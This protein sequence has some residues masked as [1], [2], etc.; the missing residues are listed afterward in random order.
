MSTDEQS[1][2]SGTAAPV[3][4]NDKVI[5][6][7]SSAVTSA[8]SDCLTFVTTIPTLGIPAFHASLTTRDTN[9]TQGDVHRM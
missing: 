6:V 8:T 9:L 4:L 7:D 2:N 1:L 5:D 3:E